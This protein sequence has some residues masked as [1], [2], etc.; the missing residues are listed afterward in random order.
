MAGMTATPHPPAV[1]LDG[2]VTMPLVGFGTWQLRGRRGY[3]AIRSALET[4]Y[5]HIDTATM[6]GNER[7]VGRA[8]ADSGLD[9][10][11]VFVT[12]K[13]PPGAAGREHD[14]ITAS[15]RALGTDH[16][17]L[18]LVHW[19][20]GGQARP[21]VW[22]ELLA[23][24]DRGLARAVG[25]SNYSLRQ[26]DELISATGQAPAVNQIPWSP[27]RH[28]PRVLA[29]SRERGVVVEGYSPLKGTNLR[30]R[31]LAGIASR[32]RVTPAQ[33][34]LRWHVEHGVAVIPKSADRRR[35]AAN[36]DLFSFRLSRE[37]V[38]E[39]DGLSR[40]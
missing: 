39:V 38:A 31:T 17:D 8:L 15:L 19:P 21:R 12:T 26:I 37:E 1:T 23:A 35:I 4:G 25:V 18:W 10:R 11:D 14:T 34:V 28:D 40:R 5:R 3:E 22:R 24:R 29:G 2:G 30:D 6:Y 32:H 9:R 27:S 16:V 36:F 7:E 33:V 13:L 20:P